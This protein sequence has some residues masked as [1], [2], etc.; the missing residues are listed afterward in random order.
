MLMI[1]RVEYSSNAIDVSQN[2]KDSELKVIIIFIQTRK[3]QLIEN[4][5][6]S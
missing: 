2:S 3:N 5:E 1:M 6:V 4:R